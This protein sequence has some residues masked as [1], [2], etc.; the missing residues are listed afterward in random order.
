[1]SVPSFTRNTW[2]SLEN[3]FSWCAPMGSTAAKARA[4]PTDLGD[5]PWN[6]FRADEFNS[7]PRP[8]NRGSTSPEHRAPSTPILE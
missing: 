5:R 6:R 4:P 8:W 2:K 3:P 7:P 1:M